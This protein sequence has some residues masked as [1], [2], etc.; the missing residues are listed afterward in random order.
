MKTTKKE[1]MISKRIVLVSV[2]LLLSISVLSNTVESTFTAT[3]GYLFLYYITGAIFFSAFL[4]HGLTSGFLKDEALNR[5]GS[6]KKVNP[7]RNHYHYYHKVIK[8]TA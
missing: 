8:K 2:M 6:D 3:N 5:I 7:N 1:G 4:I